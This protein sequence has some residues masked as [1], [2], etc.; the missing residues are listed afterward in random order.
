MT[1]LNCRPLVSVI[2][3]A[4]NRRHT[5][6]RALRSVAE[7]TYRPIEIIVVDDCSTDGT[8]EAVSELDL[9]LEVKLI[10]HPAN[11]GGSAA[12]N[13]G[14]AAAR[15]DYV[16]FLDSDDR[17]LPRKTELQ[18][19]AMERLG[20]GAAY[21]AI[22]FVDGDGAPLYTVPAV[23]EGDMLPHLAASNQMGSTSAVMVRRDI[24]ARTGGFTAGLRSC[25]DWDLWI[26]IAKLARVAAVREPVLDYTVGQAG[27]ITSSA[28][29]RLSG[30]MHMYRRHLRPL[31]KEAPW[32]RD[33][34][35][36]TVA[37]ILV[38]AGRRR[39]A[40]RLLCG[41]WHRNRLSPMRFLPLALALC[42]CGHATYTAVMVRAH[43]WRGRLG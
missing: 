5:I 29:A 24:L 7:Q 43:L 26:R 39:A 22:N 17:W 27:A 3:P 34:F 16:A 37:D 32:A 38:Q 12:R 25:Q 35:K 28:A 9:D 8:A 33:A 2:V 13:T 21:A 30:H 40:R 18:V 11:Q 36:A 6:G 14:I 15:G 23:A 42:G 4:F 10:R 1:T 19:E 20:A 41:R 31:F